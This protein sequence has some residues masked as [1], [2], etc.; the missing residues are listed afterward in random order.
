MRFF[1]MQRNHPVAVIEIAEKTGDIIDVAEVL[2]AQRIP[3][4][5]K[6]SDGSFDVLSLRKWWAGRG[7][8]ASRSGLEHALETLH[9]PYAEL[10]LVKC[11]GLSLSDQY[12]VTPCDAPQNWR[13]VNFYENDF[14]DDVGRALFGEGVLSAQPD[15]CS[16][17][18][19]SDGVPYWLVEQGGQVMS[20]CACFTNDHTEL[21][22]A[23]QFMRLLPQA[24]G[25]SNWEHFDTCCRTVGIP[26]A[27]KAVCNMLAADFILANTDR[28]LG[29]FGFLR[30]SETL[31]WKGTAPIY[32]SGTSLWQMT[33]TRAICAEAMV[34]AKPFETSQQSQLKLIAPYA[35]LPLERLDGFSNKVEEILQT[36]AQFDD[37]RAA[38]IAAAVSGRIQML[39]LNRA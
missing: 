21:V 12:W 34:P 4:G 15:L 29:N 14:S 6:H 37:G 11:S 10:L 27:R 24:Q 23:A 1:L 32:D 39:R 5:A 16:P 26:D 30:D 22:T 13:D 19:T 7:I 2:S 38:K 9:I 18:N 8:P 36:A 20:A 33:L 28:H 3:L 17:C 35:D 25:V 31:E